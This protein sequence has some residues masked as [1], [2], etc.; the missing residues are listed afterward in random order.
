MI[1]LSHKLLVP[2][3][4]GMNYNPLV[5]LGLDQCHLDQLNEPNEPNEP[6]ESTTRS[7]VYR[8]G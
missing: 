3:A 6:N 5:Q 2:A 7:P 4:Q 8:T 1:I